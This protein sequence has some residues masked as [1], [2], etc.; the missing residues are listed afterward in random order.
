VT[1][2]NSVTHIEEATFC[3]CSGLTCVTIP[4]SVTSIG[5]SAFGNCD[6][7][8]GVTI[9]TSVTLIEE[10]AF[11]RCKVLTSVTVKAT[12]PP[13]IGLQNT[14]SFYAC[15]TVEVTNP[16]KIKY[17]NIFSVHDTLYVPMESVDLYKKAPHWNRF[18]HIIGVEFS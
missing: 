12:P 8:T 10:Q 3:D 9:G 16:P 13:R 6:S 15:G 17:K 14:I 7:L 18:Q 4:D 11:N 1:I 5:E 2:S